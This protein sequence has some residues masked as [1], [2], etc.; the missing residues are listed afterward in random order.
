M[1][2]TF[3]TLRK[4][5]NTTLRAFEKEWCPKV[6]KVTT[7]SMGTGADDCNQREHE[8]FAASLAAITHALQDAMSCRTQNRVDRILADAGL[9]KTTDSRKKTARKPAK[10]SGKKQTA[11]KT[12]RAKKSTK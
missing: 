4:Q 8:N 3:K 1:P 10:K 12:A 9:P 7:M 11:K 5:L 6:S 2:S